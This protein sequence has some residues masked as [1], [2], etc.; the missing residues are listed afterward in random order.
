MKKISKISDDKAV[1][2]HIFSYFV[3][4]KANECKDLLE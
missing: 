2:N 3:E 1:E 4:N